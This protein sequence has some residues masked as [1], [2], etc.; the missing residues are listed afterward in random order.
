MGCSD[1]QHTP[2][3][4]PMPDIPSDLSDEIL[5]NSVTTFLQNRGA[6][7]SSQYDFVR[8]DLNGDNKREG[9][10]MMKLPHSY[11]CGWAGCPMFIFTPRTNDF[12][13][14]SEIQ[15][16]RGPIFIAPQK[17]GDR[18]QWRDIIVRAS[19]DNTPDRTVKLTYSAGKY[20]SN[21]LNAPDFNGSVYS[22]P[23]DKA[24]R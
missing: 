1:K 3:L 4:T 5:I 2:N 23:H 14:M 18:Q 19:G 11:W 21:T 16:V 24:F 9:L 12:M 22:K 20:A 8:A 10:V 15:N 7:A 17:D 6:P 13:M